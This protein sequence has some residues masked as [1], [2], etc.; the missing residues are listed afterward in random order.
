MWL[1]YLAGPLTLYALWRLF[2]VE[3][4]RW[5]NGYYHVH[6][7]VDGLRSPDAAARWRALDAV[8]NVR[9]GPFSSATSRAGSTQLLLHLLAPQCHAQAQACCV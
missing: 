2:F 6:Q 8:C 4:H 9:A 7:A 3:R 5:R 1:L